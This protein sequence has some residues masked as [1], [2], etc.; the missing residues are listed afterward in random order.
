V[1]AALSGVVAP[2]ATPDSAAYTAVRS[3]I[4]EWEAN[5]RK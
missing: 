3:L 4:D 5:I 2:A 1:Y